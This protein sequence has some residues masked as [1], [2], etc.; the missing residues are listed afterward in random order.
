MSSPLQPYHATYLAPSFERATVGDA[1]HAGVFACP[2]EASL[3]EVA[4]A[5]ASHRLHCVTVMAI[6]ADQADGERLVWGVLSDAD[7]L[8]AAGSRALDATAGTLARSEFL[9]VEPSQSLESASRLMA[10]HR[11]THAVVVQPDSERLLGVVS[12][13]DVAGVLAWGRDA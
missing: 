12:A 6:V 11:V 9:T 7:L 13:H 1:M 4:A 3:R 2:P 8:E 10:E 5:M